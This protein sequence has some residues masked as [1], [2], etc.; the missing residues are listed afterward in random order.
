MKYVGPSSSTADLRF[1]LAA[2][3]FFDE[4]FPKL[5]FWES[6]FEFRG[7]SGLVD[8]FSLSQSRN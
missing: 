1:D 6:Y 8:R 4:A 2:V 3:S 5:Q 7:K